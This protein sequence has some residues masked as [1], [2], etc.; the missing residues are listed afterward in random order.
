M[1]C[2]LNQP[3][4]AQSENPDNDADW[5]EPLEEHVLYHEA[6]SFALLIYGDLDNHEALYQMCD[7]Y[8]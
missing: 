2:K 4:P 3:S 1:L 8:H 5:L 7:R 6:E